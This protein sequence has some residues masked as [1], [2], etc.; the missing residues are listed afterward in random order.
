MIVTVILLAVLI[1]AGVWEFTQHQKNV[2][3][4]SLR[5]H[6]NGTRGK[7]SVTRLIA[8]GM[9]AGGIRTLAKTTGTKPRL[10]FPDGTEVPIRR[11]GK[12][13]IIEQTMVFREAV[14]RG[15]KGIV[16]ECMAVQPPLQL[17]SEKRMVRSNIGVLTNARAD[18]LDEMGP[19]IDEVARSLCSTIPKHGI[20]FT[21]ERAR[22]P[23]IIESGRKA[24]C[25]VELAR[26]EDV[27]DE[28]M[29]G[30]PYLEHK[31]NVA[32][33]LAVCRHLGIDAKTALEGMHTYTPDPG[34]LRIFKVNYYQKQIEFINAFAAN[35]PDSYGIIWE[36]LAP[37]QSAGKKLIVLVN[38]RED[39]IQ[40]SEQMGAFIASRDADHYLLAGK[41][42]SALASKAI[43]SGLS[44]RKIV[45]LGSSRAE[46]IF[47]QVL[48]LTPS[49][50]LVIG[51]GNIVGLGE[52]IVTHFFNRGEEIAYR[53]S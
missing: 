15:V 23:I 3:A 43:A 20:L 45:D 34:V 17:L 19:T 37:H 6:V 29:G 36:L 50:S 7:S 21:S 18:H 30:F 13:N 12:A 27:T 39:R 46:E 28:M 24:E 47:E 5:I 35:D 8:A 41:H 11:V 4:V 51:I 1:L 44:P 2:N 42:T 48:S 40:R 10:I 16:V 9:R 32:L 38:A 25:Q 52:E 26:A 49:R 14:S 22:L 53:S 33:A 31:D